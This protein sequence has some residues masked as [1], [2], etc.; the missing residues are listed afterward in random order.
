MKESAEVLSS[1]FYQQIDS[2]RPIDL[3]EEDYYRYLCNMERLHCGPH[4]RETLEGRW[5][6]MYETK[7]KTKSHAMKLNKLWIEKLNTAMDAERTVKKRN[8]GRD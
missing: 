2:I 3:F 1:R 5:I 4:S 8:R 6:E 7:T